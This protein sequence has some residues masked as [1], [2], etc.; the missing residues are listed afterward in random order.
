M[1]LNDVVTSFY[2]DG[3]HLLRG[4]RGS[5]R[6][7]RSSQNRFLLPPSSSLSW[8]G[9]GSCRLCDDLSPAHLSGRHV[10]RQREPAGQLHHVCSGVV[11][12]A[13]LWGGLD[14]YRLLRRDRSGGG[15]GGRDGH[16][17]GDDGLV[18]A[19]YELDLTSLW[20]HLDSLGALDLRH[21]LVLDVGGG[22]RVG[23]GRALLDSEHDGTARGRGAQA[24]G[25]LDHIALG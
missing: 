12:L 20:H 24:G 21:H 11:W 6:R 8:S 14:G 7:R 2:Q 3:L 23:A 9:R 16:G 22:R 18:G 10:E 25:E 17:S 5:R 13:Q 19:W 1:Y 15:R 4:W